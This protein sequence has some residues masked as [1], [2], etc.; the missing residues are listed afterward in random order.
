M[1]GFLGIHP[2]ASK[3][4]WGFAHLP[5]RELF[6]WESFQPCGDPCGLYRVARSAQRLECSYR[7]ESLDAGCKGGVGV[8][9]VLEHGCPG[10][11]DMI[12][13][14]SPLSDGL[15]RGCSVPKDLCD[16]LQ[17]NLFTLLTLSPLQRPPGLAAPP[18]IPAGSQASPGSQGSPVLP[19]ITYT[20]NLSSGN[21]LSPSLGP[22]GA[23]RRSHLPSLGVSTNYPSP[24]PEIWE[25]TTQWLMLG[26]MGP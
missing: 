10:R 9:Q 17:R 15:S 3:V 5:G 22:L 16:R 1:P 20:T 6:G 19:Q 18:S 12:P 23:L 25:D 21:P 11:P 4:D 2:A 7:P 14:Y 26:R 8:Q 24:H 13:R